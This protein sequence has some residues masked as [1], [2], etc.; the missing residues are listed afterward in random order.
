MLR[1]RLLTTTTLLVDIGFH[2]S[3]Q[4]AQGEL[5]GRPTCTTQLPWTVASI[6]KA[7]LRRKRDEEME[8]LEEASEELWT[9]DRLTDL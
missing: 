2:C 3:F 4:L 5:N 9:M 8:L 1:T 7:V 6:W